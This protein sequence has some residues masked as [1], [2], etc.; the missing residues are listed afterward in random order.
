MNCRCSEYRAPISTAVAV[1]ERCGVSGTLSANLSL[2]AGPSESWLDVYR[3]NVCGQLWACEYPFSESHGGGPPCFYTISAP[4][5]RVWLESAPQLASE[6]IRRQAEE[7]FCSSLGPEVGPD[8]CS[9]AGCTRLRISLSSMC[10][11]HHVEA[12]QR[13]RSSQAD[14]PGR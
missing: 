3:C 4:D 9:A 8:R 10:R 5:P 11:A 6:L 7:D 1:R 14:R 13:V 2:I 12:L